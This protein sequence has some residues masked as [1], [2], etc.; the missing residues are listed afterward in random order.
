MKKFVLTAVTFFSVL[1]LSAQYLE[2]LS[3]EKQYPGNERAQAIYQTALEKQVNPRTTALRTSWIANRPGSNWFL[4]LEG[5]LAYLG[6]EYF[7]KIDFSDN[8]KPTGGIAI[9]KWFSPV[10]GLR[11]NVTGAELQGVGSYGSAWYAGTKHT[12]TGYVTGDT[13]ASMSFIQKNIF[14]KEENY[15]N[16]NLHLY[17]MSYIGGSVDFLLNLKNFFTPYNPKA[18]FNPVVY[19]GAGMAHTFAKKD[20]TA[21]NSLLVKGGL[22]LNF[23]L[24]DAWEVYLAGEALLVPEYFDRQLGG[25]LPFDAVVNAKLGFTYRF[26]FRPFIKTPV[27]DQNQW[28]ALNREINELR[29]RPQ[30]VCPPVPVC[31][32][33]EPRKTEVVKNKQIELTPVFFTIGSSLVDGDQMLSIAKA[34]L[35]LSENPNAK[36]EIAAYS[37]KKT[38]NTSYNMKL[39]EKR[40]KVVLETLTQKFGID[41]SRLKISFYGDTV[42]PFA[43]NDK[44]RVSIF[45]R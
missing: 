39:S 23:R 17:K 16:T 29:N 37:D 5:G 14:K 27:I 18:V 41:K 11:I 28:N 8:I 25:D 30:V 43:E 26:N 40:A 22:Q 42:Q 31:P 34:A 4:S 2:E 35:Y 7:R 33:V 13:E 36:L 9:G 10:W 44:N 45:V 38:G 19:A 32:E 21:V 1:S 15:K 24:A 6:T 12:K 20:L 3:V